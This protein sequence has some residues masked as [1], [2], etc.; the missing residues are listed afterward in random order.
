MHAMNSEMQACIQECQNCHATCLGEA[1]NHCLEMGGAHVAP[2]HF[3]AMMTCAET[4][5]T[6][7]NLM[8]QGSPLH[9]KMC[10][11]CAEACAACAT[12]CEGLE[13]M[14]ECAQ[15]CRKCEESCRR[16]AAMA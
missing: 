13:G 12:S 9:P 7:A 4:C 8:L 11:V 3:R 15:Q 14:E 1:I 5:Q 2:E 10:G 16:M 6:S